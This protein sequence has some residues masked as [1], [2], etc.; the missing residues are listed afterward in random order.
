MSA[1]MLLLLTVSFAISVA[2]AQYIAPSHEYHD[3]A[4]LGSYLQSV[5]AEYPDMA[6]LYTIGRSVEGRL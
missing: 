4:A 3:H 1:T 6:H 2:T 5:V